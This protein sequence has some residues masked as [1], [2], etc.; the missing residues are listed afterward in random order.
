M[1]PQ[2]QAF[3]DLRQ[4]VKYEGLS[5]GLK[6]RVRT[7]ALDSI[8]D[9]IAGNAMREQQGLIRQAAG[10][11]GSGEASILGTDIRV[12]AP[13]AALVNG[14][15]IVSTEMDDGCS[16]AAGGP[17]FTAGHPGS[18]VMP[19]AWAMAETLDVDGKKFIESV[20]FAYEI[21]TRVSRASKQRQSIH[22][23]G[24]MAI[25]AAA[26]SA[27][28][29]DQDDETMAQS[30]A[31]GANMAVS[32]SWPAAMEGATVR[33]ILNGLGC[34]NGVYA[35]HLPAAGFIGESTALE[36]VYGKNI[37]FEFDE[38]WIK[39]GLPDD[40]F[41]ISRNFYKMYACAR[42]GHAPVD[43]A[44]KIRQTPGFDPANIE[45]FEI[46]TY[47]VAADYG[48]SEVRN[49]FSARFSTRY[50]VAVALLY[51]DAGTHQFTEEKVRD[52]QILDLFHRGVVVED[53]EY[54]AMTPDLRPARVT[55]WMKDG[56]KLQETVLKARGEWTNPFTPEELQHKFLDCSVPM[57]GEAA[58]RKVIADTAKLEEL[59]SIRKFIRDMK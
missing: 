23:H 36:T 54:T 18:Y 46:A 10:L 31:M 3:L 47:R 12:P 14:A 51:G 53:P 30:M 17:G 9:I 4:R 43:C 42:P 27:Y 11:G 50:P 8:G 59:Q 16:Y 41:Y 55:V 5:E 24:T 21:T 6:Q 48:Q 22:P 52:P 28:L 34:Q 35:A 26:V 39:N 57:I 20:I 15:G 29:M 38:H 56:R 37:G 7:L 58:A 19:A 1:Y 40:E 45:R 49:V 33:N 32:T 25:G 44:L 13:F 2:F